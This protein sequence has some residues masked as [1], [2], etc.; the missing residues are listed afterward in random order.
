MLYGQTYILHMRFCR[1]SLRHKGALGIGR[2]IVSPF[3]RCTKYFF[4]KSAS[5]AV[6]DNGGGAGDMISHPMQNASKAVVRH[7]NLLGHSKQHVAVCG[8]FLHQGRA[9][10]RKTLEQKVIFSNRHY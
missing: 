1:L 6:D 9:E 7:F 4:A 2:L 8:L 10:S 3:R 5:Y